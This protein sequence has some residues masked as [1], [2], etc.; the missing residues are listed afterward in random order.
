MDYT[1]TVEHQMATETSKALMDSEQHAV[2][3]A[4][5]PVAYQALETIEHLNN[6]LS[7]CFDLINS[8]ITVLEDTLFYLDHAENINCADVQSRIENLVRSLKTQLAPMEL[9]ENQ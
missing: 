5:P 3:D 9:G 6:N 8:C 2:E 4:I 1:K 7:Y